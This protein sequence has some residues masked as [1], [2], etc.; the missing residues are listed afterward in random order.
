MN[1][2]VLTGRQPDSGNP[3]V[4]DERGACGNV[5]YGRGYTGTYS[6]NAETAKSG[7][8][9]ARAVFLPDSTDAV[10]LPQETDRLFAAQRFPEAVTLYRKVLELDPS[11]A[12]SRN[13]LGLALYY[14]GNPQEGV[15]VL[16]AGAEAA[17]Q[18]QRIWLSLGFVAAQAEQTE[19]AREA[20]TK[21]Q[22]LDPD[23]DVGLEAARLL[24]LLGDNPKCS[25]ATIPKPFVM[26]FPAG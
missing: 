26:W 7:P 17:P 20:L 16:R 6:G 9:V 8:K 11:D 15:E 21:A 13:D 12:G 24:G 22:T 14:A 2:P 25:A 3:T 23:S 5:G 10:L 1:K 19:Q 18:F 4:R